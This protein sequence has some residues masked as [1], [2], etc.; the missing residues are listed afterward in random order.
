MTGATTVNQQS[1]IR[2]FSQFI[3]QLT[4]LCQ[5]LL[6]RTGSTMS[7]STLVSFVRSHTLSLLC[8][9]LIYAN[10]KKIPFFSLFAKAWCK[11]SMICSTKASHPS[12]LTAALW[13]SAPEAAANHMVSLNQY[14]DRCE[15]R[16]GVFG[17][18]SQAECPL[19]HLFLT[20]GR[21]K[22]HTRQGFYV[23]SKALYMSWIYFVPTVLNQNTSAISQ[24]YEHLNLQESFPPHRWPC[25]SFYLCLMVRTNLESFKTE[26]D[27]LFLTLKTATDKTML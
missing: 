1:Q 21:Q 19:Q 14:T 3:C 2:T 15:T 26:L 18:V 4:G 24:V 6:D 5:M 27:N 22:E 12:S 9:N 25:L 8:A 13:L 11:P 7:S 20:S 23:F 16:Q 10:T 17:S